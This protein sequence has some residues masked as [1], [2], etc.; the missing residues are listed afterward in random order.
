MNN[1]LW[2]GDWRDSKEAIILSDSS[3]IDSVSLTKNASIEDISFI[4]TDS[5]VNENIIKKYLKYESEIIN[6]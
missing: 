4:I 6:K 2:D 5:K 3:K 1:R